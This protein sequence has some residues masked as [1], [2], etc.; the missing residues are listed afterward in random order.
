VHVYP[1]G[2]TGVVKNIDGEQVNWGW[3]NSSV[4]KV[5]TTLKGL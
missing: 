1:V 4:Q 2:G 3:D 5:L